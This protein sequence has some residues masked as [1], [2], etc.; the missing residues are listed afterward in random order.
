MPDPS[1]PP[2]SPPVASRRDWASHIRPRLSSLRFSPAR[3]H[4]IVEELS[5][6]LED[7]W[8]E[9][10]A[11]G[12]PEDEAVHLALA[13]FREGNLLA[14]Y[15]APLQQAQTSLPIAPGVATG[16]RA[17]SV[18]SKY[19]KAAGTKEVGKLP[20]PFCSMI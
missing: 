10:A 14:R 9:L 20:R 17:V 1:T 3:E 19:R 7:R 8:G 18:G 11:G 2:G 16:T 4:E 6:H 12:T 13:E 15:M 5:Q